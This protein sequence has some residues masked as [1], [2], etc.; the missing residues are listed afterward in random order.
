[1]KTTG[2]PPV[3]LQP[4]VSILSPTCPF[5]RTADRSNVG[6]AGQG[7]PQPHTSHPHANELLNGHEAEV[8]KRREAREAN[9]AA[10]EKPP[11]LP[12]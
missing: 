2:N 1:M 6:Q 4:L 7:R 8:L 9:P 12:A 5:T 11:I 3:S 10:Q